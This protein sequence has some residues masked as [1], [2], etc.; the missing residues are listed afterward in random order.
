MDGWSDTVEDYDGMTDEK[1]NVMDYLMVFHLE[2]NPP[3]LHLV[4]KNLSPLISVQNVTQILYFNI[5][6]SNSKLEF[7]TTRTAVKKGVRVAKLRWS[8]TQ[9]EL[10]KDI[11]LHPKEAWDKIMR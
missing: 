3:W 5:S 8:E 6:I 2:H 1:S 10:V 4:V 7:T 9:A 11:K